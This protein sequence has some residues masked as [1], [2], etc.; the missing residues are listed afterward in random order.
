M[1]VTQASRDAL[2]AHTNKRRDA[3]RARIEKTLKDMRREHAQI[4]ISS[5]ARCAGVTRKSIH[6]RL[7]APK[8][9][10]SPR[11]GPG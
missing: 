6:H 4:T 7:P 1:T 2:A 9:A 11:Y 3:V 5:V 8:P 10:S